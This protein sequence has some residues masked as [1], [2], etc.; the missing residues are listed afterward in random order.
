MSHIL[1]FYL[2][3]CRTIKEI[4]ILTIFESLLMTAVK[5]DSCQIQT[6]NL[7]V[8]TPFYRRSLRRVLLFKLLSGSTVK[9]GLMSN[10]TA[11]KVL[12]KN[13]KRIVFLTTRKQSDIDTSSTSHWIRLKVH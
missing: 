1:D 6:L 10:L 11:V 13:V 12:S 4:S 8:V 7:T 3:S 5:F 2:F 9:I